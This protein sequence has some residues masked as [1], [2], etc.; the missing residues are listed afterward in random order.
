[1][2]HQYDTPAVFEI[3]HLKNVRKLPTRGRKKMRRLKRR[4]YKAWFKP[5]NIVLYRK[6]SERQEKKILVKNNPWCA[7]VIPEP[8]RESQRSLNTLLAKLHCGCLDPRLR[9][10]DWLAK[11]QPVVRM[12]DFQVPAI[13]HAR[14]SKQPNKIQY[15]ANDTN[16]VKRHT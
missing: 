7:P 1:M 16:A 3:F 12:L 5:R 4:E 11:K 15:A 14:N 10:D 6:V 9:E 13:N 2:V 8:H